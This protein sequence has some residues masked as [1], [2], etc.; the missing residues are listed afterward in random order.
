MEPS[1]SIH[2]PGWVVSLSH[3]PLTQGKRHMFS[4]TGSRLIEWHHGCSD[5]VCGGEKEQP[6][7]RTGAGTER[8]AARIL[9]RSVWPLALSAC[10]QHPLLSS[11]PAFCLLLSI[12]PSLS[13][14][15][16]CG[17]WPVNYDKRLTSH[18][19]NTGHGVA[20]CWSSCPLLNPHPP[21]LPH[22]CPI[23]LLWSSGLGV[24]GLAWCSVRP[25][26]LNSVGEFGASLINTRTLGTGTRE[27][28]IRVSSSYSWLWCLVFWSIVISL[29]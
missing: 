16:E 21:L 5:M 27:D 12:H 23:G 10:A 4:I 3:S 29:D 14:S 13:H 26:S 15:S 17:L 19:I 18:L 1:V 24:V 8:G 7:Q 20:G 22:S 6:P 2:H 25:A 11:S 28:E 9:I